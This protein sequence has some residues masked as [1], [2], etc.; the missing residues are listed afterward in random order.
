MVVVVS[1]SN[2][3]TGAARS[4]D[5]SDVGF[6]VSRVR[7]L[8]GDDGVGWEGEE[9]DGVEYGGGWFSSCLVEVSGWM[10]GL[11]I[12]GPG[13]SA[14][15]GIGLPWRVDNVVW[16]TGSEAGIESFDRGGLRIWPSV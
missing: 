2:S 4:L 3:G 13:E 1:V 8:Q 16:L 9:L 6:L 5:M 11:G 12:F 7:S 14:S 10:S 15:L